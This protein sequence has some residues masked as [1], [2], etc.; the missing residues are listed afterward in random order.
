MACPSGNFFNSQLLKRFLV[1][2]ETTYTVWFV[3]ACSKLIRI[4][5]EGHKLESVKFEKILDILR[6]LTD[7]LISL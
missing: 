3:S 1:A 2:P 7:V 4:A 6:S 5:I